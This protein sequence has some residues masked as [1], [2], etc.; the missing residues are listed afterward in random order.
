MHITSVLGAIVV[1]FSWWGV[2]MLETGLHSY[3]FIK[4]GNIIN[5]FYLFELVV[6]LIAGGFAIWEKLSNRDARPS[7][8]VPP[9]IPAREIP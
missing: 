7:G 9:D 8:P 1:A 4:G 2:N 6:V 3:G 5:W